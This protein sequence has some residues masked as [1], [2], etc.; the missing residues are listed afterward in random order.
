[1]PPIHVPAQFA[2]S[3]SVAG[4]P[5]FQ[6]VRTDYTGEAVTRP[7][8][9]GNQEGLIVIRPD[10]TEFLA[11][12]KRVALD[13][14]A[15]DILVVKCAAGEVVQDVLIGDGKKT[16]IK[17]NSPTDNPGYSGEGADRGL[18]DLFHLG[19]NCRGRG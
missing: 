8:R 1:M 16:W 12:S 6:M 2:L 4:N 15:G 19:S 17:V 10:G 18:L 13:K 9:I 5:I 11:V 14:Y 3:K 7:T